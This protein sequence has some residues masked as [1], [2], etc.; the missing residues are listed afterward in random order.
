[1]GARFHSAQGR[2]A[3]P[4]LKGRATHSRQ[5]LP[6]YFTSR[7]IFESFAPVV[8]LINTIAPAS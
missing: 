7:T 4:A 8:T 1:M 2:I 6:L 5:P 3:P